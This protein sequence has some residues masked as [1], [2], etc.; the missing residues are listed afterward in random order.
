MGR[1]LSLPSLAHRTGAV[2]GDIG[3]GHVVGEPATPDK[4]RGGKH[5]ADAEH[6][7]LTA[8]EDATDQTRPRA[9]PSAP[10]GGPRPTIGLTTATRQTRI[11]TASH[12]PH[13]IAWSVVYSE[14]GRALFP[15]HNGQNNIRPK[16]L[17]RNLR[18]GAKST[19]HQHLGAKI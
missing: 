14:F 9:Q 6:R 13:K 3:G 16:P 4:T 10:S 5:A 18:F 19:C 7:T 17:C 2:K 8:D 15:A 12:P 1:I 11:L